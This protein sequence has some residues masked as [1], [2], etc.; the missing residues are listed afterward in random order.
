MSLIQKTVTSYEACSNRFTL[1]HC[2]LDGSFQI[3]TANPYAVL[4]IFLDGPRSSRGIVM[5]LHGN[6]PGILH[7]MLHERM[8][9]GRSR[10]VLTLLLAPTRRKLKVLEKR[11]IR[12]QHFLLLRRR[13]ESFLCTLRLAAFAGQPPITEDPNTELSETVPLE[14][15]HPSKPHHLPVFGLLLLQDTAFRIWIKLD[16]RPVQPPTYLGHSF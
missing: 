8:C 7:P 2:P 4:L 5:R 6:A 11:R 12:A 15:S 14:S 9:G 16:R 3:Q 1:K 10:L 13:P